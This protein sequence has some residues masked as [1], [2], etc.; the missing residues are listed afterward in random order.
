M[1]HLT[2][3]LLFSLFASFTF[4]QA[5][6]LINYQGIARNSQFEPLTDQTIGLELKL[7]DIT[8]GSEAYVEE[9]KSITNQGG[10]F[11]LQ[12][13]SGSNKVGNL[14]NVDWANTTYNLEVSMDQ[15]G[16]NN[17]MLI[18]SSSLISVPYALHAS[19]VEYN[20]DADANP[21]NE[22]QTLSRSGN[23][24]TLSNG[25]GEVIDEVNDNDSD[26]NNEIQNISFDVASNTL[27]L[28][29][30]GSVSL[31]TLDNDSGGSNSGTDDQQISL[32]GNILS[33]EDGNSVDLT[34]I[35]DGVNDADSNPTNE[36]QTLTKNGL[37]INL[38]NGGTV[39]DEV[40]DA[41]ADPLNE[42]QTIIK[43]GDVVT[44][45]NGG[46]SFTDLINDAD[47][48]ASNEIQSLSL[49]G[50][51][52]SLSQS[53]NVDLSAIGGGGNSPWIPGSANSIQYTAGDVL[54][55]TQLV[56]GFIKVGDLSSDHIQ[57]DGGGMFIDNVS[58]TNC[59]S[60]ITGGSLFFSDPLFTK[61]GSLDKDSVTLFTKGVG[62]LTDEYGSLKSYGLKFSSLFD[63]GNL[64]SRGLLFDDGSQNVYF[65]QYGLYNEKVLSPS[66]R[67]ISYSLQ[68]DSLNMYNSAKWET[69]KLGSNTESNGGELKLSLNGF[70]IINAYSDANANG[71]VKI[72]YL[73]K[74]G[75]F[76]G[77]FEEGG[78]INTQGKNGSQNTYI[79]NASIHPNDNYGGIGVMD[80]V[81]LLKAGVEVDVNGNGYV[82]S[83]GSINVISETKN[84]LGRFD[85]SGVD[86]FDDAGNFVSS[87]TKDILNPST[88]LLYLNGQNNLNNVYAGANYKYAGD[89]NRGF[90]GVSGDQGDFKT[91]L[92][93]DIDNKGHI[94]TD[95]INIGGSPL[96][97]TSFPLRV[98]STNSF[99]IALQNSDMSQ[100]WEQ[101]INSTSDL[102]LFSNNTLVGAFNPVT[103]AYTQLSDKR[104]KQNIK[105]LSNILPQ[106]K[107]LRPTSYEYIANN[108]MKEISLGFIAQEVQKLFPMLVNE[109]TNKDGSKLLTLD[110][111]G[112]SV[113][114]IQGLNEQQATIEKQQQQIDS[115][116]ER[117]QKVENM[118]AKK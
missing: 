45:S 118:V 46:G 11:N 71:I 117:M 50:K 41:D 47:A 113:L 116:L 87:L 25:G 30:G 7:I 68:S 3:I 115:L 49:N 40:N 70:S 27:F 59:I 22:L 84:L 21:K 61:T 95:F 72:N 110:Y 42:I 107:N 23:T 4:A 34:V 66:D 64:D 44:L 82:Y 99:G 31:E 18:G 69:V 89:V 114:A 54:T 75:V 53:N 80:N 60:Q 48:D 28:S 102:I 90:I 97:P 39:T 91:E 24:I 98:Q 2:Q 65:S 62:L 33:I 86:L 6:T 88:G 38:T 112:F 79:G 16:G 96:I 13:G 76:M 100:T 29:N 74:L 81:G 56:D 37:Q 35:Q 15:T 57:L 12:I 77:S 93:V 55:N 19:T 14:A 108:D 94:Q 85:Y 104:A 5:P 43:N 32:S 63:K 52:L 106:I 17:Y 51:I 73:N 36:I 8:T 26:P 101:F 92:F 58:Q 109:V 20:D 10:L 111:S 1:K 67:Y 103:G 83:K 78:L 105:P 9:H